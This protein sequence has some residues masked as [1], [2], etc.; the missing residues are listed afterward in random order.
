MTATISPAPVRKSIAV[1]AAPERAFAVFTAN[2]GRW[3]LR[4]H[5]I[6]ASPMK[7]V[8]IEPRVGGRWYELGEDGS[9][10]QWGKV[11]A[12]EPP[13]RLLLAWQINGEWKYDAALVTEV[14]VTFI[15]DGGGTRVELEHRHLERMGD[16]AEAARQA[17]DSPGGWSGLLTAFAQSLQ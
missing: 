8:V 11:L 4:T 3:W 1:K 5:T 13:H 15:A 2:M 12:W 7:D 17:V 6:N 14:E 10:C 9:Q 16:S